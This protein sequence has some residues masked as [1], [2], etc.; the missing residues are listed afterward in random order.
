MAET[1]AWV[2]RGGV[3]EIVLALSRLAEAAGVEVRTGEAVVRIERGS[4]TT[5]TGHYP[6]DLVVSALDAD[7]LEA[8][9]G[10]SRIPALPRLRPRTLSCSAIALYGVLREELPASIATHRASAPSTT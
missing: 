10:P 5:D 7:R 3:Y 8:L 2:P 6:T 9:T 1:G 4:V